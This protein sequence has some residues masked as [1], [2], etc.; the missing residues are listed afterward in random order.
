[1][2]AVLRRNSTSLPLV[3]ENVYHASV[4]NHYYEER[5]N[6]HPEIDRELWLTAEDAVAMYEECIV[7]DIQAGRLVDSWVEEIEG[8]D[9]WS[10]VTFDLELRRAGIQ[11]P[12]PVKN[13]VAAFDYWAYEGNTDYLYISIPETATLTLARLAELSGGD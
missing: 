8:E 7:P 3:P 10:G 9:A 1:M 11:E 2:E 13:G 5:E 6:R 12:V 4:Y